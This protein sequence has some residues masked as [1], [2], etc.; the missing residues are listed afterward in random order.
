MK[1][2]NAFIPAFKGAYTQMHFE[3]DGM[4]DSGQEKFYNFIIE[5]VRDDQKD[6]VKELMNENFKKQADGTFTREDMIKTQEA[7]MKKLKPEAVEEVKT[8]MTHFASTQK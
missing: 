7:L 2:T 4:M 1:N 6:S 8:A 3:R 5:R